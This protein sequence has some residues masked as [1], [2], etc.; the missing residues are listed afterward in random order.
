MPDGTYNHGHGKAVKFEYAWKKSCNLGHM[1]SG[2]G[3]VM[4][5]GILH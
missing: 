5:F 2:H 3:K 4:E 1:T